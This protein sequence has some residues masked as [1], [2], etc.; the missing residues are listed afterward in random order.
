MKATLLLLVTFAVLSGCASGPSAAD[1]QEKA[2]RAERER[3]ILRSLYQIGQAEAR[4]GYEGDTRWM[5]PPAS[6]SL[7]PQRVPLSCSSFNNGMF[8]NTNCF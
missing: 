6:S 2:D 8:V 3:A 1:L 5:D 4:Q 7:P